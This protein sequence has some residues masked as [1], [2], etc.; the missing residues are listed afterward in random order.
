M[1]DL[2]SVKGTALATL[3]VAG[4]ALVAADWWGQGCA[5]SSSAK[6]V[7]AMVWAMVIAVW[8]HTYT[9]WHS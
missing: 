2:A 5:G 6:T 4:L 1:F 8:A 9:L 7:L 3:E